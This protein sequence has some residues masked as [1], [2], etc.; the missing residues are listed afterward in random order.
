MKI[1]SPAMPSKSSQAA[2][3]VDF[4]SF[5]FGDGEDKPSSKGVTA[6]LR[7]LIPMQMHC[8][9]PGELIFPSLNNGNLEKI[10]P[11]ACLRKS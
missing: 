7:D 9:G 8:L 3:E 2:E 5:S 1:T 10:A 4:S 6:V 11:C